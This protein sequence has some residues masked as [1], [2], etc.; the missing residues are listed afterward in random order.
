MID[1]KCKNWSNLHFSAIFQDKFLLNDYGIIVHS[2]QRFKRI[3]ENIF[4][5]LQKFVWA[6]FGLFVIRIL[7]IDLS[8][9]IL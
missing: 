2:L 9:F 4:A 3:C 1:G 8:S 6:M 7:L 5:P